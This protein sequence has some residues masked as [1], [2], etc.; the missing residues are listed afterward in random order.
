MKID[1]YSHILPA[2]YFER[3]R[4]LVA[5]PGMFKRWLELPALHDI[6]VRLRMMEEFGDDYQ[7]VLTLSSPPIEV[8]ATPEQ[9]PGLARLANESMLELCQ[10]YP[11]RF[12]AF[13]ASLPMNNPD[14]VFEELDY[15]I[16]ELGARGV[17]VFT[18]VNGKPLDEP[19]YLEIFER[20]AQRDLPVW[21][22]PARGPGHAD[23]LTESTSKYEIW[24]ALGW[25]YETSVAMSR[26]VFSGI[27]ERYPDLKIIT[28][29][30]GA[31]IPSLEGRIGLGWS[32]QLGSRTAEVDYAKLR[33]ERL[34]LPLVDYFRRFYADTAL[35]GSA[36]GVRCGLDFFGA[37]RVL[38]G[39]DCPFD[40]QGGPMYIREI[41]RVVDELDIT[42]AERECVYH[43]NV[44]GLMRL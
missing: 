42:D 19:E 29:H 22:H 40:P 20:M 12:P 31:M 7:Q 36:I 18:N 39:S 43:R 37:E 15:A 33:E 14:A 4:Q 13:V 1:A 2:P 32:D 44:R 26:L 8:L 16:D 17:Q 27:L 28:H 3:M 9:S 25:P 34:P 41:I 35:S 10:K 11:E 6:D 24:W 23:Y 5:N 21:M 30:M 38:F